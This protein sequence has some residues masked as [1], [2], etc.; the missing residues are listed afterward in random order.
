[1]KIKKSIKRGESWKS[2]AKQKEFVEK[3]LTVKGSL[4]FLS[5][6]KLKFST[7][8]FLSS[9]WDI[10]ATTKV[11]FFWAGKH[12]IKKFSKLLYITFQWNKVAHE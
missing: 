8:L 12:K 7:K 4:A 3:K 9:W 11:P 5:N 1:M 2:N 6:S 10:G